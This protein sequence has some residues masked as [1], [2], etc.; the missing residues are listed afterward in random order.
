MTRPFHCYYGSQCDHTEYVCRLQFWYCY[1]FL[2][3]YCSGL[4]SHPQHELTKRQ[5]KGFG[6]MVSFRMKG[7]LANSKA[8]LQNVK[9][10]TVHK[11]NVNHFCE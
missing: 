8:F 11:Q 1:Y 6:G 7:G 5:C 9:V 2:H 10:H 3:S 4:P